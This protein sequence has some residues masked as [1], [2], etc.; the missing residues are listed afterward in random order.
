MQKQP[1]PATV[2]LIRDLDN[3]PERRKWLEQA[4]E[5]YTQIPAIVGTA[6]RNREAWV[7]NGFL[8]ANSTETATL[9]EIEAEL[10]F[11]P[12]LDADRLRA[13]ASGDNRNPKLVLDRLTGGDFD[14]QQQCW[15]ETCLKELRD[16]GVAT[17]L[18]SY[19]KELE[20]RLVPLLTS[21]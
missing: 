8:P 11:H 7:L 6:D 15:T 10:N 19:L 20:E 18:T 5:E 17:G 21:N 9:K 3:Q 2:I 14:R 4:R 1:P 13:N 12:C 16:R